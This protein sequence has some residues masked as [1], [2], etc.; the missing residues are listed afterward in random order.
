M[1]TAYPAALDSY[2]VKADGVDTVQAAHINNLQD[3]V[4]AIETEL[5]ANPIDIGTWTPVIK[6]GA[7]TI[8]GT[9]TDCTYTRINRMVMIMGTVTFDRGANTGNLSLTGLPATPAGTALFLGIVM[10]SSNYPANTPQLAMNVAGT[11]LFVGGGGLAN[12]SDANVTTG[13]KTLRIN[14][15]YRI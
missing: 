15:V 9:V 13:T 1:S 7:T 12:A 6:I 4:V 3:A 2:A 11:L 10:D 8:T 14:G 5:G